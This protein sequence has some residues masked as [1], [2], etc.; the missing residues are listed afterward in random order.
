MST[1]LITPSATNLPAWMSGIAGALPEA[2]AAGKVILDSGFG[3]KDCKGPAHI[4]VACAMGARL[5]LDPFTAMH[6]IAVI[7]GKASLYGDAMLAVC[8]NHHEW[9]DFAESWTGQ[10]YHDDFTAVCT[11]K[12]KG[13]E[14]KTETFNV[15]DAKQATLWNKAGPWTTNPGRMMMMRARAFALRGA[16]ADILAGF[17][18]REEMEDSQLVDVTETAT[19]RPAKKRGVVAESDHQP[20]GSGASSGEVVVAAPAVESGA[21]TL[22]CATAGEKPQEQAP[23]K[24]TATVDECR[25]AMTKLWSMPPNGKL[26]A[27]DILTETKVA[28]VDELAGDTGEGRLLFLNQVLKAIASMPTGAQS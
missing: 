11:V 25:E 16:F 13:R 19:V 8:Q 5:G 10:K 18:G 7:N 28:K 24:T 22:P 21:P 23:A 3:P 4:V 2:L 1:A 27:K 20:D 26:K 15:L 17:H 12:R 14:P 6:G 9:E